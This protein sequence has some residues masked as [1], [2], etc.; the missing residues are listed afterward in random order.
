MIPPCGTFDYVSL[1]PDPEDR[2]K[3]WPVRLREPVELS[4]DS[5][6]DSRLVGIAP[7]LKMSDSGLTPDADMVSATTG[8]VRPNVLRT[9]LKLI[10][11]KRDRAHV[12]A[13]SFHLDEALISVLQPRDVLNMTRTPCGGLGVSVIRDGLLVVA[14]GAVTAVPLGPEFEARIAADDFEFPEL[15]A[16]V[17]VGS[18]TY[19]VWKGHD[20][21]P[22]VP[23]NDECL[24]ISL[25]GVCPAAAAQSSAILLDLDGL[26]M[27]EWRFRSWAS[28][29]EMLLKRLLD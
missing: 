15:S 22:G 29:R 17:K 19:D 5:L 13:A 2:S 12:S 3:P 11:S 8:L 6:F 18:L 1:V 25:N 7:M 21:L 23:G 9:Q 4:G 26:R 24:S 16:E 14:A 27:V 28:L 20:F 10:A